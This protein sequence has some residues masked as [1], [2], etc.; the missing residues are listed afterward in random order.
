MNLSRVNILRTGTHNASTGMFSVN[1]IALES[2]I[3][4]HSKGVPCELNIDHDAATTATLKRDLNVP[5]LGR[6]EKVY[7]EGAN[8]YADF[9]DV[10]DSLGTLIKNRVMS[11]RSIE[12]RKKIN[13]NGVEDWVLTAVSFFGDSEPAVK[14]LEP[15]AASDDG[16]KS[17]II[18]FAHEAKEEHMANIEIDKDEYARLKN[19]EAKASEIEIKAKALETEFETVK[20]QAQKLESVEKEFATFKASVEKADAERINAEA[21]AFTQDLIA[22]GKLAPAYEAGEI[23]TYLEKR[24]DATKFET[25]KAKFAAMQDGSVTPIAAKNILS[26]APDGSYE[27]NAKQI[28]SHDEY[29]AVVEKIMAKEKI[30]FSEANEKVLALMGGE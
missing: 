16:E 13:A 28:T 8:L 4:N 1:E 11:K 10:P 14:N 29:Y 24:K 20:A 30:T 6:A 18:I 5:S 25:Y 9:V 23:E 19:I 12:A 3:A 22:R 7:R 21:K 17:I 2:I 15:I 26:F 27:I